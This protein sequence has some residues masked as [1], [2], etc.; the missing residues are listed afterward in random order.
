MASRILVTSLG[1]RDHH[2]TSRGH[3]ERQ[4]RIDAVLRASPTASLD[5]TW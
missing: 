2:D 3:P 5:N 1:D 4:A